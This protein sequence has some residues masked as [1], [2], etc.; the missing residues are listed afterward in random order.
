M[1]QIPEPVPVDELETPS[2]VV[3]M[4]ARLKNVSADQLKRYER[5]FKLSY[6]YEGLCVAVRAAARG[7][8]VVASGPGPEVLVVLKHLSTQGDEPVTLIDPTPLKT[9][10]AQLARPSR[11]K[12]V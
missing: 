2:V 9:L 5:E 7:P 3:K 6:H 1:P 12:G 10:A 8:V 4:L 11:T